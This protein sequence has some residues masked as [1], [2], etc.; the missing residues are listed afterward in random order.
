MSIDCQYWSPEGCAIA[1]ALCKLLVIPVEATACGYC[2]SNA[3]PRP[4]AVNSVTAGLALRWA[5]A[6]NIVLEPDQQ[7]LLRRFLQCESSE[8]MG[9]GK[10]ASAK[11]IN[12]F[13]EQSPGDM[14]I[15]TAAVESLAITYPG[16]WTVGV[17]GTAIEIWD[18]NPHIVKLDRSNSAVFNIKMEY[19]SIHRS[20]QHHVPFLGSY[21]EFLGSVLGVHIPIATNRPHLYLSEEEKGWMSQV[22]EMMG[23]RAVHYSIVDAGVKQDFTAKQWPIEYYQTVV[24]ETRRK[25]QW[26]Q[27]GSLEHDHPLLDNV[28]DLRG[29][30]N[31]R[32]LIRLVYHCQGGLGPVTFLQHLC[33]AWEK[34]YVCLLGGREPVTWVSYPL[35]HTLHTMGQLDCCK[36]NA[37]WKSRVVG[38]GDSLCVQ[39]VLDGLRP[40]G[41]CMS[42]IR[43][44][45][46][47]SII[48][49][50]S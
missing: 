2:I 13:C 21:V 27:I 34:P 35:Q 15:L 46:V 6:N 18:N 11:E 47:V 17:A 20:N 9:T 38:N 42:M 33:A 49:R 31:T 3:K 10:Q 45:E 16:R 40:V 44:E 28:I 23:G 43:P 32:E 50:L 14:M 7:Q 8:C 24:N 36:D 29:K 25:T 30:T 41:R 22:A 5:R 48:N 4:K 19:P 1:G 37:C 26:V 39:P 12:L